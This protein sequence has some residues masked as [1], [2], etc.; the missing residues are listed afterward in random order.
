MLSLSLLYIVLLL[1]LFCLASDDPSITFEDLYLWGKNEYTAGNWP[2][3]VAYMRKAIEDFRFRNIE[4][5]SYIIIVVDGS[6]TWKTNQRTAGRN[7]RL[8]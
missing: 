4:C 7:A 6:D 2:D 8:R 5:V 1:P 3:C